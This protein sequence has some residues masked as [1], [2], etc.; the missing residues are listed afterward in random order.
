MSCF[1]FELFFVLIMELGGIGVDK[2]K[3]WGEGN[4]LSV[5]QG[6]VSEPGWVLSSFLPFALYAEKEE[7]A[8]G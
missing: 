2:M 7:R 8:P 5:A 4:G 6:V 1:L 3:G